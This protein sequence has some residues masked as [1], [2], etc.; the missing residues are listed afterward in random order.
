MAHFAFL[1]PPLTGHYKPLAALARELVQRGHRAT[2]IHQ[3]GAAPLAASLGVDFVA[4]PE[5]QG[6]SVGGWT[7]AMART[8]GLSGIGGTIGA[9]ARQTELLCREAPAVLRDIGA[10]AVVADQLEAAGGLVAEHLRL[11]F[12]TIASALPINREPLVPPPYLDWPFDPSA[13]GAERNRGG[14]R[15]SD[16]LMRRIG[17]TVEREALRLGLPPR[18]RL[19]DC[20]SLSL[21]LAQ[22]VPGIDFPR[23]ELPANFHYCGPFRQPTSDT[24]QRPPGDRP[25]AYCSFGT[26]QG[27]RVHLFERVAEACDRL[28]LS[29]VLTHCGRLT[30]EQ[31]A[32][33]PGAPMVRDFLPQEAVLREA[34]LVVTHAGFNTVMEA[35]TEG[36]PMVALPLAFDQPAVGARIARAKVGEVVKPRAATAARLYEAI[37]RVLDSPSYRARAEVIQTE[38]KAAGGVARAADLIEARLL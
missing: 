20:F 18:R 27:S 22:A 14:Y 26:L 11:P 15:I 21:Q 7:G 30:P 36:L 16:L 37:A 6:G 13:K 24:F 28:G 29:L 3:S 2:F 35:L 25:L 32:N 9:M 4:L 5:G 38:I 8:L 31:A 1:A 23:R 19:E 34:H 33:L 17:R 10:D 12:V